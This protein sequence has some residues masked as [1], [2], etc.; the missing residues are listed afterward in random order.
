MSLM[1]VLTPWEAATAGGV[2]ANRPALLGQ[3]RLPWCVDAT[4]QPAANLPAAPNL[5]VVATDCDDATAAGIL[6]DDRF[7]VLWSESPL[8]PPHEPPGVAQRA[9]LQA[10]GIPPGLLGAPTRRAVAD[11]VREW[12]RNR[13]RRP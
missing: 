8:R 6:A 5:L 4:A 7:V 3:H 11:A 12:L 10:L 9:R 13:P 1:H 2:T